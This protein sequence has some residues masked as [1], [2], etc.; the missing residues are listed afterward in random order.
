M[1]VSNTIKENIRSMM[2]L[3]SRNYP[4]LQR[5]LT[6]LKQP[7]FQE[8]ISGVSRNVTLNCSFEIILSVAVKPN[9]KISVRVTFKKKAQRTEYKYGPHN[10]VSKCEVTG[11]YQILQS[12]TVLTQF[13]RVTTLVRML[14]Q[15]QS[16]NPNLS[17][18]DCYVTDTA[19]LLFKVKNHNFCVTCTSSQTGTY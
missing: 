6:T 5:R 3:Y 2:S 10:K 13:K 8:N 17:D 19:Q 11:K 9:E 1:S 12:H 15:S 14:L 16:D 4:W 18:Y 7:S